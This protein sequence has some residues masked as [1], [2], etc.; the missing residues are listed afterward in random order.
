M[1]FFSQHNTA[2]AAWSKKALL[3]CGLALL[4][5]LGL[6]ATVIWNQSDKK[7]AKASSKTSGPLLITPAQQ[8]LGKLNQFE[9]KHFSFT[10]KN[11]GNEPLRIV[12]VEHS[13]GCT[14]AKASKEVIAPGETAK[15]SGT[16]DAEN[17]VGEFGSQITVSYQK[18]SRRDAKGAEQMK[19]LVGAKVV[20]MLNVPGR[21]DLGVNLLG[22]T[23]K[24]VSFEVSK[25]EADLDWDELI[26]ESG[27]VKSEVKNLGKDRWQITLTPPRGEV[28]G[29][30][31]EELIIQLIQ[32]KNKIHLPPPVN[33]VQIAWRTTSANFALSPA[34]VY[35]SGDK[36]VRIKIKS[37]QG[38]PVQVRDIEL[39]VDAPIQ[40][41]AMEESGQ[42]WLEFKSKEIFPTKGKPNTQ[43][44][45]SGKVQI[46][47]RDSFV[48][49]RVWILM[50]K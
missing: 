36:P 3:P 5:V 37:L 7:N 15:I 49:E 34:G 41:R 13:C 24:P 20:T 26:V 23:P 31:R 28:I 30:N 10:I 50:I 39:P 27:V 4:A 47:L 35:L 14:E 16:L 44:P 18:G 2:S 1:E 48:K 40:V 45:W 42:T 9:K 43:V 22:E 32:S 19:V 33:L 25:G 11:Q 21:V 17:R 12:K 46:S 8:H 6:V 38:R 29:H